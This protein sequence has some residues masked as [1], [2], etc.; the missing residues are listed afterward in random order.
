LWKTTAGGHSWSPGTDGQILSSSVG[1]VAVAP[2]RPDT[3]YIGMGE[4][5]LRGNVMQG[6]GSWRFRRRSSQ[7]ITASSG[8][9]GRR[10][11][12]MVLEAPDPSV[13]R[14]GPAGEYH[15]PDCGRRADRAHVVQPAH[16]GRRHRAQFGLAGARDAT[17]AANEVRTAA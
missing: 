5:Q 14:A 11:P 16:R 3:V 6:D 1:A 8:I 4:A 15:A 7:D 10:S 17:S 2:S 13:A 12:G 9:F